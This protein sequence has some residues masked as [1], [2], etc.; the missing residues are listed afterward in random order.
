M[1]Y[2]KEG[3]LVHDLVIV[4]TDNICTNH[5]LFSSPFCILS[6]MKNK[7]DVIYT[8][9][10]DNNFDVGNG[11]ELR[12]NTLCKMLKSPYLVCVQ[13]ARRKRTVGVIML[14]GSSIN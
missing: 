5:A 6:D 9:V 2:G 14:A 13:S 12:L 7:I 3:V 11:G 8:C 4:L 10:M 1:S